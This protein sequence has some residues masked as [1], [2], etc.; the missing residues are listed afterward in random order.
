VKGP[1]RLDSRG[2]WAATAALP[3]Q[4]TEALAE[5]ERAFADVD[6]LDPSTV[7]GVVV[8]G[9][10]ADALAG[11]AVAELLAP[12]AP[13]PV[14]V[15]SGAKVPAFLGPRSVVV[16]V[17]SS[18]RDPDTVA[19]TRTALAR[20]ARAIVVAGDGPASALAV[21]AGVPWCPVAPLAG[22]NGAAPRATLGAA[23]VPTLVA[24]ARL[25]FAD[26]WG[27]SVAAASVTLG[28]RRD[29]FGAPSGPAADVARRIGRTIPVV[30]GTAGIGAVAARRWK[31]QM[32]LNAKSP[33][34]EASLPG[35]TRD[36]LA[37]WGQDGDVTRQVMSL[38]LLR[39]AGE[40]PALAPLFDAVVAA[41][42]EVMADVITVEAEGDDDL[43]RFF[44]LALWGDFVSLFRALREG[45]DP[46]PAPVIEDLGA[47]PA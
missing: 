28:R 27:P 16:A 35:L 1:E 15:A 22:V 10:G 4:L 45:V 2:V 25:G 40:D 5:A 14:V 26:D 23:V 11:E 20:G 36:E 21:D 38:V 17:S 46:G 18:G 44:D 9:V 29:A 6:P 33:A 30:Y 19:A 37:G 12:H 24:L 34:F 47:G 41:T 31:S 3:D 43:G 42:D 7:D 8:L 39:H 32:N 13:L